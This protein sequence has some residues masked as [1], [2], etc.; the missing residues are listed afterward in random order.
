MTLLCAIVLQMK[1]ANL[2][3]LSEVL[4]DQLKCFVSLCDFSLFYSINSTYNAYMEFC[5]CY[6]VLLAALNKS[7]LL[8]THLKILYGLF[9]F[10]DSTQC[11]R[12]VVTA[13]DIA[14][15]TPCAH[16]HAH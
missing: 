3:F 4:R 10:S 9:C 12:F 15:H 8:F 6:F 16:L 14:T 1:T 11:T 2:M 7:C 5:A 13:T